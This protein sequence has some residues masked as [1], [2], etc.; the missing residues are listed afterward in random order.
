MVI[1]PYDRVLLKNGNFASIT[2]IFGEGTVFIADIDRDGDTY[3]EEIM[4][5]DIERVV[6]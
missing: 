2:E 4:L 5:S 3:T 6:Q 1:E